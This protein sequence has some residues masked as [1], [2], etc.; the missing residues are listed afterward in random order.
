VDILGYQSAVFPL[1][2]PAIISIPLAFAVAIIVSLLKKEPEASKL[3]E[4]EKLRTY[5]G[6]GSE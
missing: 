6:I 5:L 4:T 2:N 1:K 3:F